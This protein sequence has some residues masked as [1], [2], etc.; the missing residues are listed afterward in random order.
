MFL[1]Q[2]SDFPV[3]KVSTLKLQLSS[4]LSEYVLLTGPL[5]VPDANVEQNIY[6]ER[7]R[8]LL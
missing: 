8:Y 2:K 5:G 6:S 3:F 7:F 1:G 4:Q